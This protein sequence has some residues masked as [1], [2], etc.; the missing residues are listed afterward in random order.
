MKIT[1]PSNGLPLLLTLEEDEWHELE[2]DFESVED[3]KNDKGWNCYNATINGE[4]EEEIPFWAMK[5]FWDFCEGL[6][7]KEQ[8]ATIEVQYRRREKG[9]KNTAEFR[10]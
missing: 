5:P 6:S 3:G 8:K 9:G 10:A 4:E 1:A 2:I 7:K